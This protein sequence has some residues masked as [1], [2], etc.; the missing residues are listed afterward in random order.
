MTVT[1]KRAW[2]AVVLVAFGCGTA[3]PDDV[4]PDPTTQEPPKLFYDRDDPRAQPA[5]NPADYPEIKLRKITTRSRKQRPSKLVTINP[6]TGRV[7]DSLAPAQPVPGA[8]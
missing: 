2:M 7:V 6:A 1:G 4:G 8:P 3:A 5:F